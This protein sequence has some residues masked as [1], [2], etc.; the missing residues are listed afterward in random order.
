MASDTPGINATI[1]TFFGVMTTGNPNYL[2]ADYLV[3]NVFCPNNPNPTPP[4]P[5][6]PTTAI[7]QVGITSH[8]PNFF[9]QDDI[10]VLFNKLFTSFPDDLTFA[11]YPNTTTARLFAR[12]AYTPPTVSVRGF[13]KGT[14]KAPW[15]QK[16]NQADI[17][18]HYSKPLSDIPPVPGNFQ[19][20]QGKGIPVSAVFIFGDPNPNNANLVS[21]LSLYLDRYRFITDLLPGADGSVVYSTAYRQNRREE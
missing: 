5:P 1:N 9:G 7:P 8:G 17:N 2:Q 18:S 21:H 15:F 11:E 10:L 12:D 20:L 19:A 16:T 3:T 14:L 6:A 4:R 13:L